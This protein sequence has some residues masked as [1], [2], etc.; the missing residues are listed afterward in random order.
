MGLGRGLRE[1]IFF[2]G[3][4]R[5]F[6]DLREGHGQGRIGRGNLQ[7]KTHPSSSRTRHRFLRSKKP[8]LDTTMKYFAVILAVLG[9]ASAGILPATIVNRV[10]VAP[11]QVTVVR[12]PVTVTQAEPVLRSVPVPVRA[13]S[14]TAPAV[15]PGPT[16]V[17]HSPALVA[18]PAWSHSPAILAAPAVAT[19]TVW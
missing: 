8:K 5:K 3:E 18:A 11:A 17:A 9:V 14:Y 19:H 2:L 13:V 16:L 10:A 7:Y 4:S 1:E 15:I 6:S 12:Q